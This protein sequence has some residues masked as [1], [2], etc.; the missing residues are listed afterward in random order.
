LLLNLQI[1]SLSFLQEDLE[2]LSLDP[3]QIIVFVDRLVE[4]DLVVEV[5][6]VVLSVW[7]TND[8]GTHQE[9]VNHPLRFFR[10]R[11]ANRSLEHRL[12][13]HLLVKVDH[14]KLA[15]VDKRGAL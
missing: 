8:E 3:E 14:H 1:S 2:S 12:S 11:V 15:F 7:V 5:L 10:S 6:H 13:Q 9:F 4:E